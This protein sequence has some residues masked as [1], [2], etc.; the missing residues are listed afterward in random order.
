M[1]NTVPVTAQLSAHGE[2]QACPA[3][4]VSTGS[5]PTAGHDSQPAF[6]QFADPV[7]SAIDRQASRREVMGYGSRKYSRRLESFGHAIGRGHGSNDTAKAPGVAIGARRTQFTVLRD[8]ELRLH[9]LIAA[10]CRVLQIIAVK[11]AGP[12]VGRPRFHALNARI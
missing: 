11:S 7:V 4:R 5:R 10:E 6:G 3:T 1:R 9:K 8:L 12:S 2:G